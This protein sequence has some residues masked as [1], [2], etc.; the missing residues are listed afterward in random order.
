VLT[1]STLPRRK[2]TIDVRHGIARI[3]IALLSLLALA[4][5]VAACG[6]S[7]GG[8]SASAGGQPGKGKPAVTLG[9]KS[10]TEQFVLGQLYKQALEA[11]GFTVRLKQNIGSTTIAE[12]ALRSGQIDLYPEYIGVFNT[13][14]AGDTQP[15]PTV[16]AAF[17][18]GKSYAERHGYTLLPTTPFTDVDALAVKPDFARRHGLSSVAD[19]EKIRPL[20]LGAAPEFRKRETGLAGLA[21]VYGIRD[22]R[23][24]PL[25]T[26]IQYQVLDAGK[27]DAADVSSTDGQLQKGDYVLLKDPRNAFGFRNVTP[28]VRSEV[29]DREGPAFAQ[30][31]DAVSRKLTTTAM[32]QMNAAVDIDKK[33]PADVA[34][35]FLRDNG[36]GG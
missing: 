29:L 31:I 32:R 36:L 2:D 35:Q 4:G 14:V 9:T 13:A 12:R 17:A 6:G 27:V 18:A 5:G 11:R 3:A 10:S 30:T 33:D 26:G 25:T 15:Y 21:R 23:F 16:G 1:R 34:K 24:F 22:V 28:V 8:S 19:L 20:R 7:G